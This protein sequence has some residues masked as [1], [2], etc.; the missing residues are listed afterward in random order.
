MPLTGQL[1]HWD[2][3]R[4]FGF[5]ETDTG[6]RYFVHVTAIAPLAERPRVGDVMTFVPGQGRDGRAEVR[7]ATV[8]GSRSR[9]IRQPRR[10]DAKSRGITLDWRIPLAGLLAALLVLAA[11]LGRVSM[12]LV[13]TYGI[14][15][16]FSFSSYRADKAFAENGR[17]RISEAF[18]LGADLVGGIIGGLMAQAIFRHKTRKPDFVAA[19]LLLSAVH[20]IWLGGLASGLIT[21]DE[22]LALPELLR[23][24]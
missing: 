11:L 21:F 23:G 8:R 9:T 16:A 22:I 12:L 3:A 13:V 15:S 20:A 1:V 18:L 14:T 24:Q 10:A 5:I 7:S 19:T 2:D 17:R 4:G 6:Q